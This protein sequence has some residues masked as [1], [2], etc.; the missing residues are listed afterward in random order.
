MKQFY[1]AFS[2]TKCAPSLLFTTKKTS[3]QNSIT[4]EPGNH[5]N[6]I[7]KFNCFH[8]SFSKNLYLQRG[9]LSFNYVAFSNA[10]PFFRKGKTSIAS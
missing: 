4:I 5:S 9:G 7:E 2:K 8:G 3:S 6:L 1:P 10:C